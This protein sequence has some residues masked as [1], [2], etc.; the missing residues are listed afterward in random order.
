M[1][2]FVEGRANWKG[3]LQSQVSEDDKVIWI[4]AASLGEYEQAVPVIQALKQT[5][6]DYKIAVS[7]FS[8]SGYEIKKKDSKL[9]IVTYLPLDTKKNARR[10]LDILNPEAAFFVKYEIWPNL[11]D[12]LNN[13]QVKSY[14]ISG[15]F[16]PEQLYFRPMGKF[17]AKALGKFDHLF[18]QNE[19]SLKLLKNH[20][21]EQASIS[22]DTRY[23]RVI[24]QLGMDNKLSFMDDFT[25]SGELTMVFGSTWPED[26]T[27]TLD[28][29]NK[30]P[31]QVK[32]V[33]APHQINAAQIQKL[34]KDIRKKVICYSEIENQN[35]QNYEVL[36]IDTIGLLTKIYSYANM[37]YVGGGMGLSGLHNILEPAAFGIPIVIGENYDKFPEAKML[38]RLGGVFS[39]DSEKEFEG[40]FKKLV[41][42]KTFREKSGQ[43]CGHF[44][45]SEAGATQKIISSI[46][47]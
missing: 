8:P 7:F 19:E 43:I 25:A 40:L 1:K 18:V 24:A 6:P 5:H 15:L 38:R 36:I 28:A 13:R 35:L 10:F 12:V 39:V 32:L 3:K 9:D 31:A 41:T 16:R 42:D 37:A 14:L 26:L 47:L 21:F 29:M 23:D 27:I 45:N 22:G 4:H 20:G 33:I 44:V 34:K 46:D 30:A 17:M 2:L 11:M